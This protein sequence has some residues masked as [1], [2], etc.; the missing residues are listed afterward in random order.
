MA[1]RFETSTPKKL[2]ASFKEAIEDGRISTWSC[3]SQ[4]DFTHI[5]PQWKGLAWLRPKIIEKKMLILSIIRPKGKNI[6]SEIY[7]V[8]HGRFMESMLA[9]C[10]SIFSTGVA[11]ALPAED[12]NVSET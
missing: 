4:G 5:P 7:A 6:S 3:D 11:T 1:L 2:L 9:H 10:D 8:Y 12:D